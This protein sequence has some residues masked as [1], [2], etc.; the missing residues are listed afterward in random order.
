MFTK[1]LA[2]PLALKAQQQYDFQLIVDDTL[3]I[4]YLDGVALSTRMEEQPGNALSLGV[5]EG[6]VQFSD[7]TYATGYESGF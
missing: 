1:G 6:Q 2:R 4:C 7:L 5:N 3:A